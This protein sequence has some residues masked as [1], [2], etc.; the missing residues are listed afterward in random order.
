MKLPEKLLTL[1]KRS[2][3]SQEALAEKLGVS[4]QTVSRWELGT[5]Q[6][7]LG[8]L[9][10]LCRL[11]GVPAEVLLDDGQDPRSPRKRRPAGTAAVSWAGF[12]W[13]WAFWETGSSSSSPGWRRSP[14]PSSPGTAAK[15]G[16][17]GARRRPTATA[18]SSTTGI[19]PPAPS[20]CGCW[21]WRGS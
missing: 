14:I 7:E 17:P 21:P 2:G 11:F 1:R 13:V 20:S 15:P 5:A 8:S 3:L 12:C 18:G 16:T 4:R 19:S 6:P 9:L 10:P